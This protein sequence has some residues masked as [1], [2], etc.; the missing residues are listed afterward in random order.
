[1]VPSFTFSQSPLR[2]VVTLSVL[3]FF[4][5][6]KKLINVMKFLTSDQLRR[7]NYCIII[8]RYIKSCEGKMKLIML[9]D[10]KERHTLFMS[11]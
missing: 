4:L 5:K 11:T 2:L 10:M 1:M 3:R 6:E 9:K 7:N 8:S